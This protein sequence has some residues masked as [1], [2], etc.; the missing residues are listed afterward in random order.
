M[1]TKSQA[2]VLSSLKYGESDLIVKCFT[3]E[4]GTTSY[5][6]KGILK[7]SKSKLKPAYFQPLSLLFLDETIRTKSTLQG[8]KEVK[9]DY[10]YV[11]LHTDIVKS[12]IALFLSEVLSTVLKEEGPQEELF[13][14]L[15]TSMQVLDQEEKVSNFHLLFLMKLTK[16]LGIYPNQPEE[17]QK[18]FNLQEARFE[19][20]PSNLTSIEGRNVELLKE[21]ME[22]NFDELQNLS[23]NSKERQAFLILILNYYEQHLSGFR[24]P[25]SLE[26]LN[27]LFS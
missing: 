22:V 4:R 2:I 15:S 23:L 17:S 14:F 27:K 20:S 19:W 21:L 6:L 13:H 24:M 3:L 11:S 5:L 26:V 12:S 8:I 16:Y 25:K 7:A 18:Y 1:L 9:V 10:H